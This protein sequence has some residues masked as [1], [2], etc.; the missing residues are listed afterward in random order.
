MREGNFS[1]WCQFFGSRKK[2]KHFFRFRIAVLS[3]LFRSAI[4]LEGLISDSS[5][6]KSQYAICTSNIFPNQICYMYY[7]NQYTQYMERQ[8]NIFS[9]LP[10]AFNRMANTLRQ[11]WL[12]VIPYST[13]VCCTQCWCETQTTMVKILL[14]HVCIYILLIVCLYILMYYNWFSYSVY[15]HG[16]CSLVQELEFYFHCWI[17]LASV[18]IECKIQIPF[19]KWEN[20]K[21]IHP[22]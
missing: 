17:A 13:P 16:V 9:L 15:Y 4:F 10:N 22:E 6:C 20:E 21:Y 19:Q 1:I 2:R 14:W 3:I 11:P 12:T 7:I 8:I 5:D 18:L